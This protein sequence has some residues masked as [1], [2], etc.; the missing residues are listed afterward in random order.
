MRMIFMFVLYITTPFFITSSP[1]FSRLSDKNKEC[2]FIVVHNKSRK[3]TL[4]IP[5]NLETFAAEFQHESRTTH[6]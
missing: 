6:F 1:K 5:P 4:R 3:N 2:Y